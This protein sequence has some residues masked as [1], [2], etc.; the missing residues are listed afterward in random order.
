MLTYETLRILKNLL[1]EISHGEIK[2]EAIRQ[3]LATYEDFEPYVAFQRLDRNRNDNVNAQ[4]LIDY[5]RDNR[6]FGVSLEEANYVINFFDSDQ[7]GLLA[8]AE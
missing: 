3:R 6:I 7:D 4:E 2:L 1:L 8:Y 5:L